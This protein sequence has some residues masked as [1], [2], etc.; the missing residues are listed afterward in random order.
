MSARVKKIWGHLYSEIIR[1]DLCTFCGACIA[2][3]PVTAIGIKDEYPALI[4]RCIA[5]GY[6]YKQ[7]PKT[8][9]DWLMIEQK[10]FGD[11][12]PNSPIG[13]VRAV[14]AAR[15]TD[16]DILLVSQDGGATTAL[17]KYA[18]DNKLIEAAIVTG[19][20]EKIYWKPRP[21]IA[22][23]KGDLL[24]SASSKYVSSPSLISLASAVE[25]YKVESLGLVGVGCQIKALRKMQFT[26]WG[27][28][29]YGLKVK[30]AIGLF[31]SESF[32]YKGLIGEYLASKNIDLSKVTKFEIAK[33]KFIVKSNAEI[34]LSVPV[35]EVKAYGR[36]GCKL[37]DD[38]SARF[39]DI[40]VGGVDS[41][42]GWTT[43]IVRTD[44]GE[45]LFNDAVSSGYLDAKKMSIDDLKITVK[46]AKIK[47][48][49]AI[50]AAT[51]S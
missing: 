11:A 2:S 41:P 8:P 34:L 42:P 51:R 32:F 21:M 27:H 17:L 48:K 28:V 18:L 20:D 29:K 15:A 47:R 49:S 22:F 3:C 19:V 44:I 33:G 5:C 14:Y 30:F 6:C 25:E 23:N 40:S 37:C 39:A 43:V 38:F 45:S 9:V 10:I 46:L 16:E 1:R 26:D 35:K 4:G 7:C 50:V 24:K 13:F 31:C 12:A 36:K